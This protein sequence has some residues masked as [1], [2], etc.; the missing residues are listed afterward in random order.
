MST[1]ISQTFRVA[2]DALRLTDLS[3]AVSE[4][5]T[6]LGR[7]RPLRAIIRARRGEAK[8]CQPGTPPG[9]AKRQPRGS[10]GAWIHCP[11]GSTDSTRLDPTLTRL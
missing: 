9:G 6:W 1:K 5:W 4:R 2:G 11:G 8:I 3:V 10:E 7:V